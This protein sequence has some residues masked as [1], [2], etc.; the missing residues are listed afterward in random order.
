MTAVRHHGEIIATYPFR[1]PEP[2]ID[3]YHP[4]AHRGCYSPPPSTIS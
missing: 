1:T 3:P 2:A 4:T